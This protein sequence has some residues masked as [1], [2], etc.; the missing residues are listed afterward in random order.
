MVWNGYKY[1]P[2]SFVIYL[3]NYCI[4]PPLCFDVEMEI[5]SE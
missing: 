4:I 5:V 2:F 3:L 1:K